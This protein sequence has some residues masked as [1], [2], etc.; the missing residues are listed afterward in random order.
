MSIF[1]IS[2]DEVEEMGRIAMQELEAIEP[3]CVSTIAGG[4]V[5][6]PLSCIV[7]LNMCCVAGIDVANQRVT[8][9]TLSLHTRKQL[10]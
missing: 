9:L 7:P 1:R 3:G 5:S 2:R 8:T 6:R 4:Y 10:R